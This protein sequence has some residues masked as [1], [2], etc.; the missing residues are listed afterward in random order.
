MLK[1]HWDEHNTYVIIKTMSPSGSHHSSFVATD[2]FGY[3]M[4]VRD[5]HWAFSLYIRISW[6]NYNIY[7]Y[8]YVYIYIYILYIYY[9]YILYIIYMY[10]ILYIY[11][12]LYIYICVCIYRA[13]LKK[14]WA[15]KQLSETLV[16]RHGD[17]NRLLYRCYMDEHKVFE[18]ISQIECQD[19]FRYMLVRIV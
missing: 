8:M 18:W 16:P 15:I 1:S 7:I 2:A 12:I 9:I 14:S 19:L 5:A 3:M 17:V 13:E 4:Y 6:Q 11:Y 10:C